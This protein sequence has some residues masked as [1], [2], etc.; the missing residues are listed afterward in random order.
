MSKIWKTG[1]TKVFK[2][3]KPV[4]HYGFVPLIIYIAMKQE[5]QLTYVS[6]FTLDAATCAHVDIR[7]SHALLS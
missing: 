4:V 2:T 6:F 5:P 1:P 3:I 7:P